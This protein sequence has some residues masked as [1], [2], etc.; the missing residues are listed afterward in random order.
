MNMNMYRTEGTDEW[1]SKGQVVKGGFC[2]CLT[3]DGDHPLEP[4]TEAT[5]GSTPDK[6]MMWVAG[7]NNN[8]P[9]C[10]WG[11]VVGV[12]TQKGVGTPNFRDEHKGGVAVPANA[13]APAE[14]MER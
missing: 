13:G 7:K 3:N 14:V 6:Y 12:M 4:I 5:D 9:P 10:L 8:A 11:K 1:M 2:P